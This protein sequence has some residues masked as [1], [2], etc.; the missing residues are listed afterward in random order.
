MLAAEVPS[1]RFGGCEVRPVER[2]LLVDGEP[3]AVGA[4]AFDVLLALIERRDGVVAKAELFDAVWPGLVVE[5]NNLQVQVSTL[6][7]LLG[8]PAIATVPGRG[9]RFALPL[10]VATA[11]SP[12]GASSRAA[13]R[14]GLVS[15]AGNLSPPLLGR[16]AEL[17]ALRAAVGSQALV[18]VLGPGGIGKTRLVGALA[19]VAAADF[20]DGIHAVDL[21]SLA[22]PELVAMT[23]ARAMGIAS[24]DP[25]RAAEVVAQ[26]LA[27]RNML[28]VLD[29]C[30]HL[31]DAVDRFIV[32]LRTEAPGARI[33]VTSQELLRHP[34]EY[35]FRLG[36]LALP[37]GADVTSARAAGAVALFVARAQAAEPR[38]ALT[39]AN[40]KG[41]VDIC[42]QLDGIPLAIELAA[43][44][45]P[46]LGV[47]GI[48]ERL[49]ERFRLLTAGSRLALRR[50]QTLRA[51]H[52]WSHALLAQAEQVIFARLGIFAGG[53]SLE[54]AQQLCA[55]A[56]VDEWAVLD[57]L[58]ALVDKSLVLVDPGEPLRYRLLETTRAFALEQLARRDE[59]EAIAR[60]HA[61]VVLR[62]F[63]DIYADNL[64][65]LLPQAQIERLGPELDNLRAAIAWASQSRAEQPTAIALVGAA[66]AGNRFLFAL[67]WEGRRWCEAL[68][69]A[70]GASIPAAIAAR[71][72][73]ACSEQGRAGRV[74]HCARDAKRAVALYR[75]AGDRLGTYL[76]LNALCYALTLNGRTEDARQAIEAARAA[77]DPS[78][79]PRM[80]GAFENFAGVF[81]SNASSPDVARVH[82]ERYL[83]L[84]R[85]SGNA[86]EEVIALAL[87]ID[88]ELQLGRIERAV[89][90][91]R[92]LVENVPRPILMADGV[93]LRNAAT[94]LL[95]AGRLDEAEAFY[96]EALPWVRRVFGTGAFVLDD[97]ATLLERRGRVDDAARV[98]AYAERDYAERRRAPRALAQTLRRRLD[99]RLATQRSPEALERLIDEGRRLTDDE[100]CALA[101]PLP[102]RADA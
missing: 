101:F 69:D 98:A 44:R 32:V 10:D 66:G 4:R 39:E 16:D 6:R 9:Y 34:D 83:D 75:R 50:H 70:V 95:E 99:V 61:E 15:P 27:G 19:R 89:A 92:E 35:V 51:A 97:A 82:G 38:F 55:D 80:L 20:P 22:S 7:K 36:P 74:D 30:E 56:D 41:V 48:R 33:V 12:A 86:Y 14:A 46:L 1:Y 54:A 76:A 40:A 62:L 3:V 63:E 94:A 64:R 73:L 49:G 24:G 58:G 45:V 93:G 81:H 65:G 52:E 79:P 21:A 18:T 17:A 78:W 87:L 71:F 37:A 85:Q 23:A 90:R 77:L 68:K 26:A 72:W 43:A 57:H 5:E 47:D 96:R 88:A 91:A 100:A 67:Q 13:E 25:Q 28:L 84:C 31:L 2:K 11:A 102:P 59:T 42:R 29:N 8:A 53:F 60:R